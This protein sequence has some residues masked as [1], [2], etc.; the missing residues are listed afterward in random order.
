MI[1]SFFQ[2]ECLYFL[3]QI[4]SSLLLERFKL[5]LICFSQM[6]LSFHRSHGNLHFHWRHPGLCRAVLCL[7]EQTVERLHR[8]MIGAKRRSEESDT[9]GSFGL[10][11]LESPIPNLRTLPY[12]IQI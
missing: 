11:K 7:G 9:A 5:I 3:P 2:P 8:F 12:I 6:A 4:H 1:T 10:V